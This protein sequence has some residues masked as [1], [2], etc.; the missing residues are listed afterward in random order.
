MSTS[1]WRILLHLMPFKIIYIIA[2][3]E[4]TSHPTIQIPPASLDADL[5]SP[6]NLT[7]TAEGSPAPNYQWF[8]DGAPIP[9]ETR[10]FLYIEETSPEDRGNYTCSAINEEGQAVS[11]PGQ[12]KIPGRF[13]IPSMC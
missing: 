13:S 3:E 7:C 4:T 5:I 6:I 10:S 8:K 12:I 9:G 1:W 11:D 2:V